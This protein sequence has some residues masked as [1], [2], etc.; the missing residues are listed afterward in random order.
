KLCSCLNATE[1]VRGINFKL[2]FLT[3]DHHISTSPTPVYAVTIEFDERYNLSRF[4][5][6]PKSLP[7][8]YSYSPVQIPANVYCSMQSKE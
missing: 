3:S 2:N 4:M 6:R 7:P 8:P 1:N 5:G